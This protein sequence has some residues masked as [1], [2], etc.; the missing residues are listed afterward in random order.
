MSEFELP[1]TRYALSGDVNIAFQVMGDGPIDIILV[2]G[3][4][5][6]VEFLHEF[7][8]YTGFLRRL[9]TFARVVTFDKR[10]QGLS[11]AISGAP[12]LE[13]RVDDVRAIMDDI[14]SQRAVLLGF[15]EGSPMSAFFAA[16]NPERVSK[17][18][19]FG[20]FLHGRGGG[21]ADKNLGHGR[22][23]GSRGCEPVDK[24]GRGQT[25]RQIRAAFR[26]PR[27][28]QGVHVVE[29]AD[30]RDVDI[31]ERARADAR[32]SPANR[33]VCSY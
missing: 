10:G 6:H 19:L 2:P 11:D 20:G 26:E 5:S 22:C 21:A 15:S 9:A 33:C 25:A 31:A 16:A 7:P 28:R 14:G 13:Q 3:V 1:N 30:R 29:Q 8:E 18:I 27:H 17:L 4:V 32:A 23:N 12:S 24:S